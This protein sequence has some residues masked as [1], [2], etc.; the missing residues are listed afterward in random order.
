MWPFQFFTCLVILFACEVAAGIWGFVNK[1]QVSPGPLEGQSQLGGEGGALAAQCGRRV[2]LWGAL[3][4]S[5][6]GQPGQKATE[7]FVEEMAWGL[8][9]G[10]GGWACPPGAGPR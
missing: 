3:W 9:W 10:G 1:D 6:W 4:G 7:G 8:S 5:S 2:R